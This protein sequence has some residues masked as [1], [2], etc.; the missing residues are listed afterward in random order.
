MDASSGHHHQVSGHDQ[1]L[2][3]TADV[4][5]LHKV[6]EHVVFI[7]QAHA[8]HRHHIS[9]RQQFSEIFHGFKFPSVFFP[10]KNYI[11]ENEIDEEISY[12]LNFASRLFIMFEDGQCSILAF[13]ASNLVILSI[14]I[15]TIASILGTT[16]RYQ[17]H[18]E[19]CLNPAC[20][21]GSILC[22]DENI[23]EPQPNLAIETIENICMYIFTIDYAVCILTC[24]FVPTR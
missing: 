12:E 15:S 9:I 1:E 20:M 23:C 3:K 22:P 2:V 6:P 5:E 18:P 4:H 7:H 11:T 17:E 16:T 8:D 10:P 13:I 14:F 24:A 21:A 19:E